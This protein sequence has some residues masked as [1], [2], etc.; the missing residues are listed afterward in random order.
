MQCASAV[1][2]CFI[3]SW[4]HSSYSIKKTI[5][6]SFHYMISCCCQNS[7]AFGPLYATVFS[8]SP[9]MWK[10][11]A[12]K[13]DDCF[14]NAG[15]YSGKAAVSFLP[16]PFARACLC[17]CPCLDMTRYVYRVS[18]LSYLLMPGYV[19]VTHWVREWEEVCVSDRHVCL[20]GG[21]SYDYRCVWW[22]RSLQGEEKGRNPVSQ[23]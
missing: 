12:H 4:L 19:P 5:W 10:G 15:A 2:S 14:G 20:M 16:F 17:P 1:Y 21:V 23:S 7:L 3:R 8:K 9:P 13:R 6:V 11:S 18:K 22:R